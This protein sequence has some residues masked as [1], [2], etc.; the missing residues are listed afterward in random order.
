MNWGGLYENEE[1]LTIELN[2]SRL[3][4]DV[5]KSI[6]D[7]VGMSVHKIVDVE[8]HLI[9]AWLVAV[10]PNDEELYKWE[11]MFFVNIV[12]ISGYY[13][14]HRGQNLSRHC[15]CIRK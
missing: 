9:Q 14:T 2:R 15:W 12:K 10:N 1:K 13:W 3:T 6:I 8:L 11:W 7:L 5:N 4:C